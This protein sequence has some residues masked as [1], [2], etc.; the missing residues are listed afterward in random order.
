MNMRVLIVLLIFAIN[1]SGF[2]TA[3][4]AVAEVLCDSN[5]QGQVESI[6]KCA[7]HQFTSAVEK[8]T[9]SDTSSKTQCLDCIHCCAGHVLSMTL[10]PLPFEAVSLNVSYPVLSD[11]ITGNY[12]F[13]LLRPPKLAA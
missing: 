13:S 3:A 5:G 10:S 7:D 11:R 4:H 1:C 9:Q 6:I 8:S 12:H 2:S